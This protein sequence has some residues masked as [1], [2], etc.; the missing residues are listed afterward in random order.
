MGSKIG[1]NQLEFRKRR[2]T[3]DILFINRNNFDKKRELN[4]VNNIVSTKKTAV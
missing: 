4:S 2:G 1:E 3:D